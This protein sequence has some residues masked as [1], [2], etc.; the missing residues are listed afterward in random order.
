MGPQSPSHTGSLV[1]SSTSSDPIC[2]NRKSHLIHT[3]VSILIFRN[4][5]YSLRAMS[6]ASTTSWCFRAADIDFNKQRI[7]NNKTKQAA[8]QH[9]FNSLG[10]RLLHLRIENSVSPVQPPPAE[11]Q[12]PKVL[13]DDVEETLGP[14]EPEG[15]M[16]S[17]KVLHV[18]GTLHVIMDHPPPCGPKRLNGIELP[19]LHT[20]GL[21]TWS[22]VVIGKGSSKVHVH[23]T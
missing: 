9:N 14:L 2:S 4:I 1:P 11:S 15:N 3:Q 7:K 8:L 13:V 16:A 23:I 21:T 12:S 20:S 18:V 19:L 17:L 5:G 22:H 6:S 10:K